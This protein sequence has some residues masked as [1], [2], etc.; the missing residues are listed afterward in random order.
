MVD[1]LIFILHLQVAFSKTLVIETLK[2]WEGEFIL[3]IHEVKT[4][5]HKKFISNLSLISAAY[6][7]KPTSIVPKLICL[8]FRSNVDLAIRNDLDGEQGNNMA[9]NINSNMIAVMFE[10]RVVGN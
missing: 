7:T 4:W 1:E 5:L 3:Q 8:M 6:D 9:G 10:T 2:N